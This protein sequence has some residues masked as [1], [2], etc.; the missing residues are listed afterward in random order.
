ME[1]ASLLLMMCLNH[2][3]AGKP[4]PVGVRD[5]EA[6]LHRRHP[7]TV[8]G[9]PLS[10]WMIENLAFSASYDQIRRGC[11][12]GYETD[13]GVRKR[14]NAGLRRQLLGHAAGLYSDDLDELR[15]AWHSIEL[16]L[17]RAHVDP[18]DIWDAL[19]R[20]NAVAMDLGLIWCR[21][22]G[23]ERARGEPRHETTGPG[24]RPPPAPIH[25]PTPPPSP[26]PARRRGRPNQVWV[27]TAH[28]VQLTTPSVQLTTPN[29]S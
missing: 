22:N 13:S 24:G 6:L 23:V 2:A 27:C 14:V 7:R 11:G 8:R 12:G 1:G 25:A 21:V 28:G 4:R 10:A 16:A 20:I 26:S 5:V 19:V 3:C 9:D 17:R 15:D 18:T 29:R